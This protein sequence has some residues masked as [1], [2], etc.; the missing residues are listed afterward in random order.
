MFTGKI[1]EKIDTLII[2]RSELSGEDPSIILW[3][4]AHVIRLLEGSEGLTLPLCDINTATDHILPCV[5]W[6]GGGLQ[7]DNQNIS[8]R[9]YVIL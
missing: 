4:E 5:S 2:E 6:P 1:A 3:R 7:R 9:E 8:F